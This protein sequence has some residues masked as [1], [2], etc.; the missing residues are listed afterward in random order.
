[1]LGRVG[2]PPRRTHVI[3]PIDDVHFDE[4]WQGRTKRAVSGMELR[5]MGLRELLKNKR[6]AGRPKDLADVAS[7]RELGLTLEALDYRS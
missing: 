2:L 4:A 6:A 1:L 7:L 5:F 3:T